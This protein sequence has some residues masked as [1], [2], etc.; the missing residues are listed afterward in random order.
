MCSKRNLLPQADSATFFAALERVA[1]VKSDLQDEDT[2]MTDIPDEFLDPIMQSVMRDPV[3]LPVSRQIIDRPTI[4]RHLL[5]NPTGK[6]LRYLTAAI[7]NRTCSDPFNRQPLSVE[8]L[9]PN[10]ELKQRIDDWMQER[11]R[12]PSQ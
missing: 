10:P 8:E 4:E 11:K 3:I 12:K 1:M 6:Q 9:I 2:L 5:N 7:S